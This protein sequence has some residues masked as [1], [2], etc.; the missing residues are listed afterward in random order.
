MSKEDFLAGPQMENFIFEDKVESDESDD[1][2]DDGSNDAKGFFTKSPTSNDSTIYLTPSSF[3]SRSRSNNGKN[4]R[5]HSPTAS[6]HR[7]I[8]SR[9]ASATSS[10]H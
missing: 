9:S 1:D 4:K 5:Q 2:V 8:R 7:S 6:S 3:L 10:Q